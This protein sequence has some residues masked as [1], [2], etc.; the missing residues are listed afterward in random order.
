M[1]I[2]TDLTDWWKRYDIDQLASELTDAEVEL[3]FTALDG[4]NKFADRLRVARE[5]PQGTEPAP[6]HLRAL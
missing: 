2:W 3:F 1:L 5:H 4:S 6:R